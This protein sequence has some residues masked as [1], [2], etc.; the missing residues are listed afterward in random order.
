VQAGAAELG[1]QRSNT[2]IGG[3]VGGDDEGLG[4]IGRAGG[5]KQIE[6]VVVAGHQAFILEDEGQ[7]DISHAKAD[8]GSGGAADEFDEV[9]VAAATGDSAFTIDD[10]F[11]DDAGVVGQ[12]AGDVEIEG[13]PIG[14]A[15]GGKFGAKRDDGGDIDT[16]AIRSARGKAGFDAAGTFA[17]GLGGETG[18]GAF[19]LEVLGA[20]LGG[21]IES[22]EGLLQGFIG[23]GDTEGFE[24]FTGDSAAADFDRNL[25]GVKA[26]GDE[27]VH[28]NGDGIGIDAGGVFAEDVAIPLHEFAEAATLGAFSAEAGL[29]PEPLG[30]LREGIGFGGVE[31]G[32]GGGE[33][34]AEGEVLFAAIALETEEFG[35]D[36]IATFDGVEVEVFKGGAVNFG[37]AVTDG[38]IAPEFLDVAA[39]EEIGGVKVAGA[40]GG[41][42]GVFGHG[43][44]RVRGRGGPVAK[45]GVEPYH[46]AWPGSLKTQLARW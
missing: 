14:D 2:G 3:V 38:G 21:F 15:E 16:L 23:G 11:K 27:K 10:D 8:G 4:A 30:G 43:E 5:R 13:A 42:E 33:L 41:L 20:E 44:R 45:G 26:S 7:D 24:D 9:V 25:A 6:E 1:D 29:L 19:G 17:I 31:A 34:G 22:D 39:A 36:A 18:S 37:K 35:D 12:A 40:V 32:E 46:G 28:G